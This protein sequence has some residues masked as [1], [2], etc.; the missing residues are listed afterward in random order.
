MTPMHLCSVEHVYYAETG[1]MDLTVLKRRTAG[2][3]VAHL[4]HY[5]T[6]AVS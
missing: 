5:I 3:L 4:I 2:V 6:K 1:E